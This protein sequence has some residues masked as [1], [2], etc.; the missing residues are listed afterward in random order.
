[1]GEL[2]V[3]KWDTAGTDCILHYHSLHNVGVV[4][5]T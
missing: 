5:G 3:S 4:P 1:M 2:C